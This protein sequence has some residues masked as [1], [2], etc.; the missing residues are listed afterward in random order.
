MTDSLHFRSSNHHTEPLAIIDAQ[1]HQKLTH[2]GFMAGNC[3][4][5]CNLCYPTLPAA[6][7]RRRQKGT[8]SDIMKDH[9]EEK[10]DS[11]ALAVPTVVPLSSQAPAFLQMNTTLPLADGVHTESTVAE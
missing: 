5:A 8:K 3:V 10:I 4:K 7:L 11:R 9:A 2:A 6:E 1:R